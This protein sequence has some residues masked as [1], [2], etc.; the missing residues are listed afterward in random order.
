MPNRLSASFLSSVGE[1]MRPAKFHENLRSLCGAG[2][3]PNTAY[4]A[5]QSRSCWA[6]HGNLQELCV[7]WE[8]G[9]HEARRLWDWF[10]DGWFG[11]VCIGQCGAA[12]APTQG[13]IPVPNEPPADEASMR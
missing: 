7:F 12:C 3:R 9:C 10:A 4:F 11:E 1:G 8:T 2:C 13:R 5:L 6:I